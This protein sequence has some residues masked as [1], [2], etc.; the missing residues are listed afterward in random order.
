MHSS[1]P[2]RFRV[3][4]AFAF[5]VFVAF[6]GL[7]EAA[8]AGQGGDR[9]GDL[10]DLLYRFI[11]FGLLVTILVIV[12]RKVR[13]GNLFS[14]RTEE[15]SRHLEELKRGKEEVERQYRELERQLEEFKGKRQQIIAQYE[16]E[17]IAERDRIVEEARARAGEIVSQAELTVQ[18]EILSARDR[19][20]QEYLAIAAE[21]AQGIIARELTDKDQDRLVDEFIERVGKV[22]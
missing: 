5:C 18:Q 11:N 1:G 14:A 7:A 19:L 21:R 13:I 2:G 9:S 3:A 4:A 15:I 12:L 8:G 16:A 20:R 22:H 17:G 10:L 6:S